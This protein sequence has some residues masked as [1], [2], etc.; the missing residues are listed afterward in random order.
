MDPAK[1]I[2]TKISD[3]LSEKG[4][5]KEN[6]R[7]YCMK[8]LRKKMTTKEIYDEFIKKNQFSWTT[9]L[10]PE[11][12]EA[13]SRAIHVPKLPNNA[14]DLNALEEAVK[15]SDGKDLD[16]LDKLI[17]NGSS[18]PTGR[19]QVLTFFL[20]YVYPL[21]YNSKEYQKPLQ[22]MMTA[23]MVEYSKLMGEK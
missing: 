4:A 15:K 6:L 11:L 20:K 12:V 21:A 9:Q 2:C 8:I 22:E 3:R 19:Y 17:R 18:S 23:K 16:A 14:P 10:A 7:V 1:R 5:L 13:P